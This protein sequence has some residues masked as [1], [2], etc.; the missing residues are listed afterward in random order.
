M[1]EIESRAAYSRGLLAVYD[2]CKEAHLRVASRQA[3]K[4]KNLL[5]F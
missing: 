3:K 1:R 2:V 5:I 4:E